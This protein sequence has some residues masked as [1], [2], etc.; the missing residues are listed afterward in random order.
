VYIHCR[1][2]NLEAHF[3]NYCFFNVFTF[4]KNVYLKI[5]NLKT[6]KSKDV[7]VRIYPSCLFIRKSIFRKLIL[8][9]SLN[10]KGLFTGNM[11]GLLER[12]SISHSPG[13]DGGGVGVGAE[14]SCVTLLTSYITT[15]RHNPKHS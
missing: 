9:P 6:N 12:V 3:K 11:K 5:R 13:D 2:E 8:F 7:S 4:F 10:K 15:G 1:K 14:G